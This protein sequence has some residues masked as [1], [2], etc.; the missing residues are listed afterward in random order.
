MG[1]FGPDF[2][3]FDPSE[4]QKH[5]DFNDVW[6]PNNFFRVSAADGVNDYIRVIGSQWYKTEVN[7]ETDSTKQE[8]LVRHC[9][10]EYNRWIY[11]S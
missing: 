6:V 9:V 1:C 8:F 4:Y 2:D 5:P 10:H 3:T 11:V 7:R